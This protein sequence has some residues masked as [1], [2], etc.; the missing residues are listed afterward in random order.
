MRTGG[1]IALFLGAGASRPFGFP[2]TSEILPALL[3]RLRSGKLFGAGRHLTAR[4]AARDMRELRALLRRFVPGLFR[5]PA[6]APAVTD[7]LSL[8]DQLIVTGSAP[9]PDL[10]MTELSRLRLLLERGVAEV[11]AAPGR[12]V[13]V[14]RPKLM[15]RFAEWIEA[16][17]FVS[18]ISTNYDF[19]LEGRLLSRV[20]REEL[21]ARVDF[22]LTWRPTEG[23]DGPH[24]RPQRP[25]LA[26]YKLHGSLNWLRC[27]LCEHVFIHPS[28]PIFRQSHQDRAD[29]GNAC[30]CGYAPLRHVLVAPSM[31]RDVRDPNLLGIWQ[32]ALEALRT[33]DEWA[34]IGYSLPPE[35]LV[36]RSMLLRAYR[37][38]ARP[39]RVRVVQRR[40]D[41]D[42]EGRYRLLFPEL[43]F[44]VRGVEGFVGSLR[45]L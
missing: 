36:I 11:L 27:P 20:A 30:T 4:Q 41:R 32:S 17:A 42:V 33:S 2:V 24:P 44:D 37:G 1:R 9:Q 39:P 3:A 45:G 8:L 31:V 6:A 7:L 21:P 5:S 29:G 25:R 40:G 22:G 12:G 26:I 38:R 13:G 43:T 35:D 28:A 18:V 23:G 16:Q 10:G 34:I 14:R 15:D 19:A